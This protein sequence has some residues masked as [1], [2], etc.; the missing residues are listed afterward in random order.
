MGPQGQPRSVTR[1]AAVIGVFVLPSLLAIVCHATAY[2]P[3]ALLPV[4]III[5]ALALR[6]P[7]RPPDGPSDPE[8]SGGG[9]GSRTPDPPNGLPGGGLPMLDA[10]PAPRRYRGTPR[11]TLVH[12]R[13]RRPAREPERRPVVPHHAP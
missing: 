7:K 12:P 9:G 1:K 2:L 3:L 4:V 13:A 10:Q 5:P 8:D 6:S 11:T